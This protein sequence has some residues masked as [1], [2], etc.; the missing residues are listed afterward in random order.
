MSHAPVNI[1]DMFVAAMAPVGGVPARQLRTGLDQFGSN[2]DLVFPADNLIA[3]VKTLMENTAD[4]PNFTPKVSEMYHRWL[5]E[6]RRVPVGYG[7]FKLTTSNLPAECVREL[8]NYA[9]RAIN[10][11][12]QQANNQIKQLKTVLGMPDA[13]G[14]LVLCNTGN[15]YL[16]PDLI[17]WALN[18]ALQDQNRSIQWVI[19]MTYGLP[20]Y[21][22]NSRQPLE[23]FT[24]M[25]RKGVEPM[26]SDLQTRIREA[27]MARVSEGRVVSVVEASA[28]MFGGLKHR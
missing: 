7:A 11:L 9:T 3:E 26:P 2:A 27:W 1:E 16:N 18:R 24:S 5:S 22:P 14:L 21:A 10:K 17:G 19:Y 8:C 20:V 28:D 13:N 12:V 6:G 23:V 25:Y 4:K 15:P